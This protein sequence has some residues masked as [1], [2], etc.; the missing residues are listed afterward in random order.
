MAL[1]IKFRI[2]YGNNSYFHI[3]APGD[4]R[5]GS[6]ITSII[7]ILKI[8]PSKLLYIIDNTW[9]SRNDPLLSEF[10][11]RETFLDSMYFD[12][13][14]F[15]DLNLVIDD[16]RVPRSDLDR[17][18]ASTFLR[19]YARYN[20][21]IHFDE[22]ENNQNNVI[23]REISHT[24]NPFQNALQN[25]GFMFSRTGTQTQPGANGDQSN[26]PVYPHSSRTR[27]RRTMRSSSQPVSSMVD[28]LYT[29]T[30]N[31]M[32]GDGGYTVSA[33]VD[34]N[35]LNNRAT[36]ANPPNH[37]LGA[38]GT[39]PSNGA[40]SPESNAAVDMFRQLFGDN[41]QA[42]DAFTNI[43]T[44]PD[45]Q[46]LTAGLRTSILS[47][48]PANALNNIMR[49]V[50]G[51]FFQNVVVNLSRDTLESVTSAREYSE[52]EQP[53][54]GPI[55]CPICQS[56]IDPGQQVRETNCRH[57]FHESCADRWFLENSVYCPVCR[58]DLREN[59]EMRDL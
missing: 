54:D 35:P 33:S 2:H 4:L 53:E 20:N 19:T 26:A 32:F 31:M 7:K 16:D 56:Q 43:S 51:S 3:N 40:S 50:S 13:V 17:V 10:G 38:N 22:T 36:G 42:L 37:G 11:L 59:T 9:R 49:G 27:V 57:I 18:H 28:P 1:L 52:A 6:L 47:Q 8:Q 24:G 12:L 15:N 14:L 25:F 39:M 30:Y 55:D 5:F 58:Q 46:N 23:D 41:P 21:F 34:A 45:F 29:G 48:G 44:S